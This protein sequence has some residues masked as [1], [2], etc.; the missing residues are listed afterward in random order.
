MYFGLL[1]AHKLQYR[2]DKDLS[3]QSNQ[4]EDFQFLVLTHGRE[5]FFACDIT[6]GSKVFLLTDNWCDVQFV[7]LPILFIDRCMQISAGVNTAY[8]TFYM[9][10]ILTA[11]NLSEYILCNKITC[12][13]SL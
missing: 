4:G 2:M 7:H 3:E 11:I 12:L 9:L 13:G 5:E 8:W 10:H 6:Q 1:S